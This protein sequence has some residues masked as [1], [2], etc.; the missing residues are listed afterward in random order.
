MIGGNF[1]KIVAPLTNIDSYEALVEAGAD[2]F[3]CGIVPFEWLKKYAN[4][5]PLNRRE[6]I[7]ISYNM[8]CMSSMKI[9][10]KK[11]KKYGIPV[12]I[13]FNSHYYLEEQYPIIL[14]IINELM[15][16][17]FD[18][19]IMADIG[20]IYYLREMNVKCKIHLSGELEIVN[21]I[22]MKFMDQ[23]DVS[24]Y[25]FPRKVTIENIKNCIDNNNLENKEYEA[26]IMNAYCLYSG[27]FCNSIHCDEFVSACSIPSKI[28][29]FR[30]DTEKFS[31]I[32][33]H[34]KIKE[35][36][37]KFN[38]NNLKDKNDEYSFGVDGCGVC[39]VL[40]LMN[41]GVTHLKVVGRGYSAES[42]AND[43]KTLKKIIEIA[44]STKD[45]QFFVSDIKEKFLYKKCPEACYYP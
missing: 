23:F 44:K 35:K 9:L 43:I 7:A 19:F 45:N 15:E 2:E 4:I 17:G 31:S 32:E 10:S 26:F 36:M 41:S 34:H 16:M 30:Y 20:L 21:S 27:G 29:R 40:E 24:R 22:S 14:K 37:S 11:V 33:R 28:E 12:K 38:K 39:R 8:G 1:M 18:T 13:T 6:T 5:I 25:V 42:V 3:F